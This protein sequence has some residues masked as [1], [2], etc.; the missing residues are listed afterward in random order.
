MTTK[1]KPIQGKV[2]KIFNSREVALNVGKEQ[3]VESGML[4]EILSSDGQE[5]LDPDSG[6]VLESIHVPKIRV[7][8]SRVHDKTSVASTYRTK[9]VIVGKPKLFQSPNWERRYETIKINGVFEAATEDLEEKDSYVVTGD[10]VVQI[11]D[12]KD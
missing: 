1:S 11:V 3:G 6:E 12:G 4:F 7:K 9:R 10:L 5:I 2:A 8:V